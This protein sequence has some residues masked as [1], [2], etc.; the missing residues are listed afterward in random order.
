MLSVKKK[1]PKWIKWKKFVDLDVMVLDKKENKNGTFGYTMGIGPVEEDSIKAVEIDGDF[2]MNVGKTTNT[3]KDVEVGT[4]IRVMADEIMGNPKK[5]F[6]LF[7]SKF[8]EIPEVKLPDKLITLE[9]L[10]TGGKKS[11]GDYKI[12]AYKVV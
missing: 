2:Y 1:N 7:N 5:G 12:D 10:T 6:S 4:I 9:F 11:L 3:K 8:H